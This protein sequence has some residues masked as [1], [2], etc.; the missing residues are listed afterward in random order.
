M[1][2]AAS[3]PP[4]L[5]VFL[6]YF[7]LLCL[8]ALFLALVVPRLTTEVQAALELKANSHTSNGLED[9]LLNAIAARLHHLPAASPLIHPALSAGETAMKMLVGILFTFAAAAY[10]LFE[11]DQAIDTIAS[12][13]PRPGASSFAI[14]GS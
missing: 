9:R 1:A 8:V 13:V 3:R 11:R 6:H 7:V 14:P 5:G 12:L 10:W 4:P 2:R